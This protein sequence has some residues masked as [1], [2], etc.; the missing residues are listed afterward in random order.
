[1]MQALAKAR[2]DQMHHEGAILEAEKQ[3][4][5]DKRQEA[6]DEYEQIKLFIE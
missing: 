3:K 5:I 1:M 2:E 6:L 4:V